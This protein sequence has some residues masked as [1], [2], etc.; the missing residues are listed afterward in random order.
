MTETVFATPYEGQADHP[1]PP[2]E[3]GWA[4]VARDD[5]AAKR[6]AGALFGLPP[7]HYVDDALPEG[8]YRFF[9]FETPVGPR[10]GALKYVG[11]ERAQELLRMG[12]T[13]SAVADWVDSTGTVSGG[14]ATL[15]GNAVPEDN[16]TIT[17]SGTNSGIQVTPV[18]YA[19]LSAAATAMYNAILAHG[20]RRFDEP[21]YAG[22][23]LKAGNLTVDAFPGQHTMDSLKA[24]LASMGITMSS[25][26]PVYP[27]LATT[28]AGLTGQQAYD[29]V[30]APTWAQWTGQGAA[31]APAK[32]AVSSASTIV[33]VGLL[34]A[35][36]I[37]IAA[38]IAK[39]AGALGPMY[40]G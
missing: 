32:P 4:E 30:N 24:T 23:Q 9:A 28:A 2:F 20:Y 21:I 16:S 34:A 33:G 39:N 10:V 18:A 35:L 8:L 11:Q 36:G 26:I 17:G 12:Q 7:Y 25:A 15:D 19:T 38:V 37:T 40:P 22:Y 6:R 1:W 31:P 29:G 13:P 5:A 3:L 14:L 27:W